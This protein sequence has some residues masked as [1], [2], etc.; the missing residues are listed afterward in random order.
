MTNVLHMF[1]AAVGK[2]RVVVVGGLVRGGGG[3]VLDA[4]FQEF[5]TLVGL[6]RAQKVLLVW[7]RYLA[8]DI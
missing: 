6:G 7:D 4:D 5:L 8:F 3:N 1:T 2:S